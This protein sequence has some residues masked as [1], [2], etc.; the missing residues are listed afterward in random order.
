MDQPER[1]GDFPDPDD[2]ELFPRLDAEQ[3]NL[4]AARGERRDYPT[5]ATLFEQGQ[6]ETPLLVVE[7]GAVDIFD[8]STREERYFAQNRAGTFVGDLAM[9]TGEPTIAACVAAER[10]RAIAL[11]REDLRKLIVEEVDIGDLV[12]RTLIARREWLE[13]HG[14]GH[15]RLLGSRQSRSAFEIRDLLERNLVPFRWYD[16]DTD[17]DSHR[18]RTA[19][20]LDDGDLP[21][22]VLSQDVLRRPRPERVADDLGLRARLGREPYDLLVVGAGPA[23]LAAAVYGASEGLRTLVVDAR[24]PGGQAGTSA[25]IENYLGFPTGI[26]GAKLTRRATLQARKFGAV[27]SSA[28]TACRLVPA[29]A[30]RLHRLELDDGQQASGRVVIV[31]T[32]ADY[33]RLRVEGVDRYEGAG[34]YYTVSQIEVDQCADQDVVVVGGGNSAGQA[35]VNLMR[36]ARQVH[37]VVRRD[38]LDASMSRYLVD[39]IE[40]APNVEV[41]LGSELAELHG[42]RVLRKVGIRHRDTGEVRRQRVRGAYVLIGADPRN[43][44][45][46]GLVGLDANG[47]V[48]TGDAAAGHPDFA[49]HWHAAGRR[50]YLVETTRPGVLAVGDIRAGSVKRVAAAV[51]DG[52]LAIRHAHDLL[53]ER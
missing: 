37:L 31:A 21:V 5:G 42:A 49:E 26:S 53:A 28:H 39:R 34:L 40:A 50:P 43:E 44:V 8:R 20:A 13:G 46:R 14:Y 1:A 22:L 41:Y 45:I 36:R 6:R 38:S 25:R 15:L 17:P 23:G 48:C 19:F 7:T 10:T 52:A 2:P 12:L 3:L 9:F 11:S 33:R 24:A 47:F 27:L 32:G 51:G 30:D 4:L 29:G 16:V 18:L 35:V